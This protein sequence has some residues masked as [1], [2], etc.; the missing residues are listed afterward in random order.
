MVT[1][2]QRPTHL[3]KQKSN[4]NK[5]NKNKKNTWQAR[6]FFYTLLI[7]LHAFTTPGFHVLLF[8][9]RHIDL[10]KFISQVKSNHLRVT[11][12]EVILCEIF[13][14]RILLHFPGA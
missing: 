1:N 13:I 6:Y 12:P 5:T 8:E 7:H 4:T 10:T 3:V 11:H 14:I 9:K 2:L